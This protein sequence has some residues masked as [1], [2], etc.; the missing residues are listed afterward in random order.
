V[1]VEVPDGLPAVRTG[2]D[3][4]TKTVFAAALAPERRRDP[5]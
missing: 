1:Q 4:Q 5:Q 3:H 2:V